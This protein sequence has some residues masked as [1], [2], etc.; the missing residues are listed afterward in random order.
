MQPPPHPQPLEQVY[1]NPTAVDD[2]L[3][4]LIYRP[5]C[6]PLA[7]GVFVSV[8]TGPPG[9]KPQAEIARTAAP[10]LVL[11]GDKDPFTP[12]EEGAVLEGTAAE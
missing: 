3:V 5:S 11:W 2:E 8:I 9:P 1:R 4:E 6:D 12:G 7:I 10:L